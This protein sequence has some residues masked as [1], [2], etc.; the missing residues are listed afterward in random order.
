MDR[1]SLRG[2][3]VECSKEDLKGGSEIMK[4]GAEFT[5]TLSLEE[6]LCLT[7]LLGGL[8]KNQK[9]AAGMDEEEISTVGKMYG[10]LSAFFAKG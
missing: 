5:L 7:K 8:S 1:E 9:E 6:A 4:V 3:F 10:L 2:A